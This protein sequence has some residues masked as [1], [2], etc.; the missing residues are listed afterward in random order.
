[1][2]L[3]SIGEIGVSAEGLEII[4]RPSFYAMSQIGSPTE[5]VELFKN[6][7]SDS[8]T[9]ADCIRVIWACTDEDVSR[10]TGYLNEKLEFVKG[11]MTDNDIVVIAR[12]LLKHG[13]VGDTDQINKAYRESNEFVTEFNARQN[14]AIAIAHL[15]FS[16]RDAWSLTMTGLIEALMQKFPKDQESSAPPSVEEHNATME[17]YDKIQARRA[18]LKN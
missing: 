15:G 3:T 8:P 12:C 14:A 4:L 1:V 13:V 11:L 9:L 10:L 5:I 6:V 16:E 2:I 7:M 18:N 17:W